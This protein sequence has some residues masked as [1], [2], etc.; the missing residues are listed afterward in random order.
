MPDAAAYQPGICTNRLNSTPTVDTAAT[1]ATLP[2]L[3]KS[4][5]QLHPHN[6]PKGNSVTASTKEPPHCCC[7]VQVKSEIDYQAGGQS[8]TPLPACLSACT[9]IHDANNA[10]IFS[11]TTQHHQPP[12]IHPMPATRCCCCSQAPTH[13]ECVKKRMRNITAGAKGNNFRDSQQ[14]CDGR[15][16]LALLQRPLPHHHQLRHPLRPHAHCSCC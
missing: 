13:T 10:A 15:N 16:T 8:H 6:T 11:P 14:R 3:F 12:T 9:K 2:V 7:C 5:S 4:Q 1:A